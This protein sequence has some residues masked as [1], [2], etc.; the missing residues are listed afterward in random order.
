MGTH[1]LEKTLRSLGWNV[2][3]SFRK[4]LWA[5]GMAATLRRGD[6]VVWL[7]AGER[8]R[9]GRTRWQVL[10]DAERDLREHETFVR[11][12]EK[13]DGAE[14]SKSLLGMPCR[15]GSVSELG[16]ALAAWGMCK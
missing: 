9:D 16:V 2:S 7:M 8:P 6:S 4:G 15:F 5:C 11:W 10:D 14:G 1:R 12:I 13:K 3:V